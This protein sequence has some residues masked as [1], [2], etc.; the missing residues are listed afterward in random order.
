MDK[1]RLARVFT[2]HRNSDKGECGT[3]YLVRPD[4]LLTCWHAIHPPERDTGK[5]IEIRWHNHPDAAT[6][7]TWFKLGKDSIIWEDADLD[8]ALLRCEPPAGLSGWAH[9]SETSPATGDHWESAGYPQVAKYDDVQHEESFAG[10]AHSVS[11]GEPNFALDLDVAPSAEQDWRG[12]SGMPVFRQNSNVIMGVLRQVPLGWGGQRAHATPSFR[13]MENP[14][15]RQAVGTENR[16]ARRGRYMKQL[17][18]T[19]RKSPLA[20]QE[21]QKAT[22]VEVDANAETISALLLDRLTPEQAA[23]T[24]RDAYDAVVSGLEQDDAADLRV[25]LAVLQDAVEI[26][27]PYHCDPAE[28]D[29]LRPHRLPGG[30]ALTEIPC[31]L[32]M[33]AEIYMAGADDRRTQFRPRAHEHEFPAGVRSLAHPPHAGIGGG[34]KRH[35]DIRL[36][37]SGKFEVGKWQTNRKLID[38]V[39]IER[40]VST[41]GSADLTYEQKVGAAAIQL[42]SVSRKGRYYL[43]CRLPRD[44]HARQEMESGL[45]TLKDHY[46]SIVILVLA[47]DG[48]RDLEERKRYGSVQQIIR[49]NS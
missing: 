39:L 3:G 8:A 47:G 38:D 33:V 15:F 1:S 2:P 25:A 16:E 43:T 29:G 18:A 41:T 31:A 11:H 9:L 6:R 23:A 22:D 4:L 19:F 34:D 14:E 36:G 17:S 26:I 21:I 24:L 27:V 12:A 37:L 45:R 40:F 44:D 35:D 30:G 20:V 46:P 42:D 28:Y 5:P 13:L 48:A 7:T 49:M 10:T 32:D